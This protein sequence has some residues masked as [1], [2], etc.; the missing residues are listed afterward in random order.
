[1]GTA[2]DF[3]EVNFLRRRTP[4]LLAVLDR[5]IEAAYKD[6]STSLRDAATPLGISYAY[7]LKRAHRMGIKRS[8]SI[9]TKQES[10]WIWQL[11][12]VY[13]LPLEEIAEKFEVS[14]S[15][16]YSAIQLHGR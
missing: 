5:K 6:Q 15:C 12:K 14:R 10:Q 16:I 11:Y 2:L 1:M 13:K 8:R 3:S 9:L 7:L 4:E